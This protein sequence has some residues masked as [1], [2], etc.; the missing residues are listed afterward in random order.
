MIVMGTHGVTGFQESFMGSNAERVIRNAE[1]PVLSVKTKMKSSKIDSIIFA[2][3]F[4]AET[5]LVLPAI[6]KLSELFKA[7]LVLMKIITMVDF[8]STHEAEKQMEAFRKKTKLYNYS[9]QIYYAYSREE[10]IRSFSENA[11]A[12]I[13]A[14]G[15]HGRH[16]LAHFFKGSIAE[17]VVNHA[18]LP[19]LTLNF[20]KKFL[21]TPVKGK[22]NQKVK[23]DPTLVY[24]IPSI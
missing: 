3:D 21:K 14:L 7:R 1:I 8:Q 11:G 13:I 5:E 12:D 22:P 24:Q 16:G 10:G 17:E 4:S 20:H 2:T 15:T 18:S 9:T 6:S 23:G 19:V